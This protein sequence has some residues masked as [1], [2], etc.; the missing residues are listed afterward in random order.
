MEILHFPSGRLGRLNKRPIYLAS[1]AMRLK[2]PVR[3]PLLSKKA[4]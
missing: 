2:Q 1:S 4:V 3:I